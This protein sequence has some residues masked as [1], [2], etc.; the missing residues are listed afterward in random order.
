M[1]CTEVVLIGHLLHWI[2]I[3]FSKSR[4]FPYKRHITSSLCAFAINDDGAD[5]LSSPFIISG[6]ATVFRFI[7]YFWSLA[8]SH[9]VRHNTPHPRE[10]R[11]R[12]GGKVTRKDTGDVAHGSPPPPN[13]SDYASAV[14]ASPTEVSGQCVFRCTL[15]F[16]AVIIRQEQY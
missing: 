3:F 4:L 14:A 2:R 8:Q 6:S 16:V 12:H 7:V 10:L 9:F 11:A 13:A 1:Y 5:T 15:Y